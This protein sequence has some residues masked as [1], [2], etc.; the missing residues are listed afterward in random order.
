MKEKL[1]DFKIGKSSKETYRL[2]LKNNPNVLR[3]SNEFR[4][5][6]RISDDEEISIDKSVLKSSLKEKIDCFDE[7][8]LDPGLN[9]I[10][11]YIRDNPKIKSDIEIAVKEIR[12][13]LEEEKKKFL[14]IGRALSDLS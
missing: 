11:I 3:V 2:I 12:S 1:W 7:I 9:T 10:E 8:F 14:G 6:F 4:I 5:D 13:L